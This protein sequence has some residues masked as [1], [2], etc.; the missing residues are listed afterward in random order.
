ML[1]NKIAISPVVVGGFTREL[2]AAVAA[3]FKGCL[4]KFYLTLA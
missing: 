1:P 2:A 3:A 4:T